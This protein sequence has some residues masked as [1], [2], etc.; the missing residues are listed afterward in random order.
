LPAAGALIG[1]VSASGL[2]SILAKDVMWS[3]Q[4]LCANMLVV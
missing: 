3:A 4:K 1:G 2:G